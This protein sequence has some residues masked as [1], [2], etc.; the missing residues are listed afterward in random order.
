MVYTK[1]KMNGIE[2]NVEVDP[3]ELYWKCNE[4]GKEIYLDDDIIEHITKDGG[5]FELFN[6]CGL[7]CNECSL[8]K[9]RGV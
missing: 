4:C 1:I 9:H 7:L 8:K 3:S 6:M 5:F 2:M